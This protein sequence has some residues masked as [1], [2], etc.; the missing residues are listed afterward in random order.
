MVIENE[1]PAMVIL[2][3]LLNLDLSSFPRCKE[4]RLG[5]VPLIQSRGNARSGFLAP[6]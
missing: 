1:L 3:E 2:Q 5:S 4:G 6:E